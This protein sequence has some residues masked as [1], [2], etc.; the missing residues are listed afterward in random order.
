MTAARKKQEPA[1]EPNLLERIHAFR[2]ELDSWIDAK[3]A[4]LKQTRDGAGMPVLQ[5]RHML[6]RGDSCICRAAARILGDPNA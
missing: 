4:D 3:V 2:A 6:T 5:L 1:P